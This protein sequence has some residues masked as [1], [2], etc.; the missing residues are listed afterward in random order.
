MNRVHNGGPSELVFTEDGR[1]LEGFTSADVDA[2]DRVAARLIDY[3]R[4][5]LLQPP[6]PA[7]AQPA[8]PAKRSG[9]KTQMIADPPTPPTT[10]GA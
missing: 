10:E 1:I 2:N 5:I 6:A 3:G 8:K 7:P 9:S 4:L